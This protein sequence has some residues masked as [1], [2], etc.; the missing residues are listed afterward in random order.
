MRNTDDLLAIAME[1]VDLAGKRV[2]TVRPSSTTAKGDRDMATN[3]DYAVEQELRSL[4]A[5]RTP[6][7]G[8]LGEKG[9]STDADEQRQMWCLDPVD[10]TAS[11]ISGSPLCGV[12]LCLVDGDRAMLG[13][14]DLPFLGS[15]YHAIASHGAFAG[16][17]RIAVSRTRHLHDAIVAIGDYAVGEGA[18]AKNRTRIPFANRLAERALRVRMHGSA[19]VDLAWFAEGRIDALMTIDSNNPWDTAAGVL[20]AREAGAQVVDRHGAPHHLTSRDAIGANDQLLS[21]LLELVRD[22]ATAAR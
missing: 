22:T 8:F 2:L 7:I 13:V 11:F 4:L 21:E 19:A 15:R 5:A 3:V 10:G 1:A 12:A 14:I 16:R 17:E 6:E 9:G 18:D 20:L